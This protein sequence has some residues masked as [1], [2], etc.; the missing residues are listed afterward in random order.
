MSKL[1]FSVA[2]L[3]V[4]MLFMQCKKEGTPGP[5]GPRGEQGATG[6]ANVKTDTFRLTN[7]QWTAGGSYVLDHVQGGYMWSVSR[8]HE[9][10]FTAITQDVLNTGMVLCYFTPSLTFN[11]NN[12]VPLNYS[13]LNPSNSFFYNI[14]YETSVGK[15]KL[16]YFYRTNI[17][18]TDP[19]AVSS[20]VIPNYKFKIVAVSGTMGRTMN[21]G[22]AKQ[23]HLKGKDYTEAQLKAMPYNEVC[24]LLDIAP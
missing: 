23:L 3:L 4:T 7:A 5:E 17:P 24:Q 16:Y 15:V 8:F 20:A 9:R 1:F 12:W 10:N 22:T 18:G 6:N 13:M 11:V 21:S 14:A 19:P 2:F